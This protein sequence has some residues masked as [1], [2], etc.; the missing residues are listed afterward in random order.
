[1]SSS[2]LRHGGTTDAERLGWAYR[3]ALS[4]LPRPEEMKVLTELLAK[5]RAEFARDTD[6]ANKLLKVGDWPV[7]KDVP[8]AEL[9]AWTSAARVIL[10]LHETITR[11]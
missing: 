6:G 8:A 3:R 7:P 2:A 9:A 4:R 11:N 5:H 1:M 10:N